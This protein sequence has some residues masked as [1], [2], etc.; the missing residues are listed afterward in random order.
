M[1]LKKK[2][3][4]IEVP[5]IDTIVEISAVDLQ[6][7]DKKSIKLDLTRILHG[8]S[9]EATFMISVNDGRAT[10]ELKRLVLLPFYIQR[11]MR[12]GISYV[13]DSFSCKAID[14]NL[15]I[16]PFLITRNSVHRAVRK[17]LKIK[18]QETI[19]EYCASKNASDVFSSIASGKLQKELALKLKK[20]Y[21]LSFCEIR[22][23]EIEKG[24]E[25]GNKENS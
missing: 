6:K 19:R 25:T 14:N 13:E 9:T 1:V 4:S 2:S 15:R 23:A 21:P 7:L 16:K 24:K 22:I 20:I 8:R 5:F 17:A 12:K 18:A 10:A 11:A 3:M